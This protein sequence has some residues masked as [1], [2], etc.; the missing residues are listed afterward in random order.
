MKASGPLHERETII[1]FDEELDT[2]SVWTA[3][4]RTYNKLLKRL[5]RQYL[6]EDGERHAHFEFPLNFITLPRKKTKKTLT[7][8]Q[9]VI[10]R[11]NLAR[12]PIE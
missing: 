3:S 2:A 8:D 6:I 1:R 7:P 5:G 11:N 9:K 10:I 4:G 12:S